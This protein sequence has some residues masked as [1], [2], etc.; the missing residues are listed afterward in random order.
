MLNGQPRSQLP[1]LFSTQGQTYATLYLTL[2]GKLTRLDTIQAVLVAVHDMIKD[3]SNLLYFH[4]LDGNEVYQPLVKCL[5]I[6]DEFSVL[7]SLRILAILIGYVTEDSGRSPSVPTQS[8]SLSQL[9]LPSL[10]PF[11]A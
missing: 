7:A 11:L 9:S 4:G 3:G 6:E 2:L 10:H 1:S 5:G 8:H